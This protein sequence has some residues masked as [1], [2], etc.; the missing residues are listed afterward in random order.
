MTPTSV[1]CK[2]AS[3]CLNWTPEAGCMLTLSPII[4]QSG[5]HIPDFHSQPVELPIKKKCQ[6]VSKD[7]KKWLQDLP[8]Q[9]KK[10]I[11]HTKKEEV[12][13]ASCTQTPSSY[14]PFSTP[15]SIL[16]QIPKL[17]EG[18]A[19]DQGLKQTAKQCS[20]HVDPALNRQD[21]SPGF[22]NSHPHP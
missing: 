19:M 18:L 5:F 1:Q 8:Y 22:Y 16:R 11:S 20:P 7:F 12:A 3:T 13:P 17:K 9:D 4:S 2:K 14:I 15:L 10:G 21:P 6:G